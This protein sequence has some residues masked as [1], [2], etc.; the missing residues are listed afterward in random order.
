MTYNQLNQRIAQLSSAGT[1]D[2][3]ERKKMRMRKWR[4]RKRMRRR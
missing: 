4:R 2:T 3:D 1:A